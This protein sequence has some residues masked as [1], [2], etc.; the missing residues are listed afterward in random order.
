LFGWS[1][2]VPSYGIAGI[3]GPLHVCT[4]SGQFEFIGKTM[5][6]NNTHPPVLIITAPSTGDLTLLQ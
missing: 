3:V 6:P 5:A 2:L 1:F 4:I